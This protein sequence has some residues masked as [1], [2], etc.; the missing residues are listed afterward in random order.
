MN[1]VKKIIMTTALACAFAASATIPAWATLA[2]SAEQ[3]TAQTV[4]PAEFLSCPQFTA[5]SDYAVRGDSVAL[6][7]GTKLYLIQT[8]DSS[9]RKLT[10]FDCGFEITRLTY[11]EDKLYL[12]NV[13]GEAYIYPDASSPAEY[14][15]APLP[16]T[17]NVDNYSYFLA[18]D[19]LR[20]FDSVNLENLGE[21]FTLLKEY[22]GKA[23]VL[24]DNRLFN[25]NGA[26]V[27]EV[28][29][30]YTDFTAASEISTGNAQEVLSGEYTVK[31]VTVNPVTAE[32]GATYCTEI[33]LSD[34]S[35][36]TFSAGKT[37][38]V[39][40]V[41][42]ALAIA[43]TGNATIIIMN[44]GSASKS[45]I[46][47]TSALT[48]TAYSA[49]APDMTGAYALTRIKVYS[50]PYM[51]GAT[52]LD[53]LPQGA[54]LTVTEKFSLNF[55]EGVFYK[56]SYEEGGRTV[57]GYVA[58]NYLSPYSFSA[59]QNQPE[60]IKGEFTYDNDM[61]TVIIVLLIVALVIIA[62]AYLTVVG[63]RDKNKK[64]RKKRAERQ[65]PPPLDEV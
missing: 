33:D 1:S 18:A 7:E 6:A 62:I 13:E 9:D 40:G 61:Q 52:E 16:A 58:A 49:T 5:L 14:E 3:E 43:E 35:S 24:K 26:Q 44:D 65:S 4:Y 56:V 39:N 36:G 25:L 29:L 59:E 22:D 48:Q 20:C 51:C 10:V 19:G 38:K 63:T 17:L 57:T 60:N 2:A 42:S 30:E 12:G 47:L 23:Y 46:T 31:T 28:S 21:G 32:G 53:I 8:D 37:V 45:Y 41:R 55:I 50:R 54:I 34:L 64:R 27:E 15:F 11:A